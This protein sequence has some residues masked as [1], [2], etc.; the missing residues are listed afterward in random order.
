M[1]ALRFTAAVVVALAVAACA[2]VKDDETVC[3]EH[4]DLR[5]MSGTDCAMD[6]ARGCRVCQ[7]QPAPGAR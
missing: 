6:R 1:R 5:C 4:R 3:P 2:H 7:C